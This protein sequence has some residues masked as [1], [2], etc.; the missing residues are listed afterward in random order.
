MSDDRL[1]ANTDC[2]APLVR[3]ETEK[4]RQFARRVTCNYRC[5]AK[6]G[7]Q[8]HLAIHGVRRHSPVGTGEYV[9]PWPKERWPCPSCNGSGRDHCCSGDSACNDA[10]NDADTQWER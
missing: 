2:G 4:P 1:C 7:N 10:D 9:P 3:R 6:L 8:K 5:G